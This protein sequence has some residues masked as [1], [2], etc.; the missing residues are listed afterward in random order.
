MMNKK[1]KKEKKF[2]EKIQLFFKQYFFQHHLVK[3]QKVDLQPFLLQ[4]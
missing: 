2:R 4:R 1:I 3:S